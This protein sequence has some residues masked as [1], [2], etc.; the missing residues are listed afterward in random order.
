M[1]LKHKT[2]DLGN[3]EEGVADAH[4]NLSSITNRLFKP[5]NN[6]GQVL[7]SSKVFELKSSS[8][9]GTKV[10]QCIVTG[11]LLLFVIELMVILAMLTGPTLSMMESLTGTFASIGE[12]AEGAFR[13][14]LNV[15][16]G[17]DL[18]GILSSKSGLLSAGSK[19][20]GVSKSSNATVTASGDD[21]DLFSKWCS[22]AP[23]MASS[24]MSCQEINKGLAS[25]RAPDGSPIM[26]LPQTF[27]KAI[28]GLNEGNCLCDED[29]GNAQ[30]V[31]QTATIVSTANILGT[32][33]GL[34]I[35]S[36]NNNNC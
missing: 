16:T 14:N 35:K 8:S 28:S 19:L 29:L 22:A 5:K 27:C 30:K 1:T 20:L 11:I 4:V 32:L 31:G 15:D 26:P 7:P 33:C 3:M 25:A 36:P 6:T 2:S 12:S 18:T 17:K 23:C 21:E 13:V 24:E 9:R 10:G 34:S